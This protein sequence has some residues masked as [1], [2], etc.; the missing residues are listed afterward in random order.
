MSTHMCC[1]LPVHPPSPELNSATKRTGG[2]E[3]KSFRHQGGWVRDPSFFPKWT[4]HPFLPKPSNATLS[5]PTPILKGNECS[6]DTGQKRG[7]N[8]HLL[9]GGLSR[10]GRGGNANPC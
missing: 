6:E 2:K 7:F 4:L 10:E 3:K 1:F 9:P 8:C 5:M